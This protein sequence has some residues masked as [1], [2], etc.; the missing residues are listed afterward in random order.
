LHGPCKADLLL[1]QVVLIPDEHD[2]LAAPPAEP[3]PRPREHRHV[4]AGS[5]VTNDDQV[6]LTNAKEAA[7]VV[8]KIVDVADLDIEPPG[9]TK[10]VAPVCHV[11]QARVERAQM[12]E[13]VHNPSGPPEQSRRHRAVL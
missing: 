11:G 13:E 2:K 12:G 10:G 4:I 9:T 6:V 7:S 1:Q 3:S 8:D 5:S